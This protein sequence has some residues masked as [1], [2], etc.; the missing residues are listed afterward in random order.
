MSWLLPTLK[1]E[2]TK[3]V[4]PVRGPN[5]SHGHEALP[6][7]AGPLVNIERDRGLEEMTAARVLIIPSSETEVSAGC[8][9]ALC[10]LQRFVEAANAFLRRNTVFSFFYREV[11]DAQKEVSRQGKD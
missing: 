11:V 10:F 7:H 4:E 3:A 6:H 2:P 5:T 9:V 8:G 1:S